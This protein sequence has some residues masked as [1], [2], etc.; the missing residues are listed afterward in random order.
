MAKIVRLTVD[1]LKKLED[2]LGYL[3]TEGRSEI[4]ERIKIARG[5]GDLSENSE[6]DDAKNEQ[7]KIE[8]RIA[9]IEAVLKNHEIISDDEINGDTV[10]IGVTVE[11]QAKGSKTTT[12]YHI[13][14]TA[15]ADP[16]NAKISDESPVGKALMGAKVGKKVI[17]ETPRGEVEYKIVSI[18]K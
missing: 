2:E 13:V 16:L 5:Y 4:A 7:A 11:I 8:A 15:E 9:E 18:K 3:K 14:G 17:V 1:G 6:Y 12:T 10:N